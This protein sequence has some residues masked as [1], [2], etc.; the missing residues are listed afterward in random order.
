MLARY[1][2]HPD[3]R[4][5]AVSTGIKSALACRS[6]AQVNGSVFYAAG[7]HPNSITDNPPDSLEL[8]TRIL[9]SGDAVAVGEIG[10]D[11]YRDYTSSEVQV[12]FFQKQVALAR[13]FGLPII[14]HCREAWAKLFKILGEEVQRHGPISGVLHSFTGGMNELETCLALGLHISFAG[15]VT[16]KKNDGLRDLASRV[17][18]NRI[19]AETDAPY[20]APEPYRGK[21]NEPLYVAKTVE[22]LART[23]GLSLNEMAK[24]LWENANALFLNRANLQGVQPQNP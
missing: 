4:L 13:Q 2:T 16:F 1:F 6:L 24:L 11:F 14:I 20:L 21:R 8:L 5:I 12:A 15:M 7:L 10:L 18:A 3:N 19:L 17:P 9:E 22:C 23:K